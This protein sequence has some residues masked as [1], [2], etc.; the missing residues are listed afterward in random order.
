MTRPLCIS[1]F[2][3]V[4]GQAACVEAGSGVAATESRQVA[5]FDA[6]LAVDSI[7]VRVQAG[8]P[9]DALTVTC[10]DNLID[11]VETEVQDGE[12]VVAFLKG[13]QGMPRTTCQVTTGNL[14]IRRL[15]STGSADITVNSAVVALATAET[16][17][18]G[19]IQIHPQAANEVPDDS[20]LSGDEDPADL[21][22]GEDSFADIAPSDHLT[23]RSTGSGNI[24]VKQADH[25]RVEIYTTGSGD[26]TIKGTADDLAVDTTG[27]GDVYARDLKAEAANLRSTG[28]GDINATA[29]DRVSAHSTG[30]GDIHVYGHPKDVDRRSTGSGDIRIH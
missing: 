28:S 22:D 11:L 1:L 9:I 21:L 24:S 4:L 18:S 14:G 10:D 12:L 20:L 27:S 25:N 30:S 8:G 23:L 6:I 15:R 7:D 19:D 17:G 26:V 13:V 16:T 3:L 29:T 5:S 2:P